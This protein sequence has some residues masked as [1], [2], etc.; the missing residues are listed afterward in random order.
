MEVFSSMPPVW[1]M[2]P[3]LLA[4]IIMSI[5][6]L[7]IFSEKVNRA[8]IALLG[9]G[10]M[11][12]S[13]ILTQ[14]A[15]L[16]GIDF[17]TLALLTGMMIIVGIAE[18]SGIFQFVAVWGAKRVK[19][20]PRGLLIVLP[21]VTAVFSAFL[22]NVTTVLLIAPVTFQITRT[23]KINP[24]PYLI[25][26]IFASNIGGTATL[27]GDPPNILIVVYGLCLSSD[28]G[29]CSDHGCSAGYV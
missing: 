23:L 3:Q 1:G 5:C 21:V 12:V 11:I 27:I 2:S 18:K 22:D 7:I 9:A 14:P 10:L 13:G 4:I 25:L 19:A 20:S 17:N 24:Y 8:V 29:G 26:E 28:A 6:Y 15:A 16:K